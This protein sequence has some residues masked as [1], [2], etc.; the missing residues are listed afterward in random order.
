MI[1]NMRSY[2]R[3]LQK[4]F[5]YARL[6]GRRDVKLIRK[7]IGATEEE[8]SLMEERWGIYWGVTPVKTVKKEPLSVVV[9]V[10]PPNSTPEIDTGLSI[11]EVRGVYEVE[12]GKVPNR[13]KNDKVWLENKIL[14]LVK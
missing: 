4:E 10:E 7:R 11:E 14:L 9:E 2:Q 8:A 13:Y 12:I 6:R 1:R 3:F 5:E